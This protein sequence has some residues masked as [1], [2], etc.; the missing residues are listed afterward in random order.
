MLFRSDFPVL[1][2]LSRLLAG[3]LKAC[4]PRLSCRRTVK[5]ARSELSCLFS[6]S[7]GAV[8]CGGDSDLGFGVPPALSFAAQLGV[9][10]ASKKYF[11]SEID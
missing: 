3:G 1:S 8:A 10:M 9:F 4:L 6:D 5:P 2:F 11:L 7:G